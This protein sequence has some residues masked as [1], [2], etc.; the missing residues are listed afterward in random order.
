MVQFPKLIKGIM[1]QT[2][3]LTRAARSAS[4]ATGKAADPGGE[5]PILANVTKGKTNGEPPAMRSIAFKA[6]SHSKAGSGGLKATKG[7][8]PPRLALNIKPHGK[9]AQAHELESPRGEDAKS[10]TGP[11]SMESMPS[12]GVHATLSDR[13]E[14]RSDEKSARRAETPRVDRALGETRTAVS[15]NSQNQT[16][17]ETRQPKPLPKPAG[18]NAQPA[19]GNKPGPARAA[20]LAV[21]SP[22]PAPPSETKTVAPNSDKTAQPAPAEKKS[23]AQQAL[24]DD[25]DA[26]LDSLG[27]DTM[28]LENEMTISEIQDTRNNDDMKN[29]FREVESDIENILSKNKK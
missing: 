21:A 3:E 13:S 28:N 18:P 6:A 26:F 17:N 5:Q 29:L 7:Q 14:A 23:V 19:Q 9:K 4:K 24:E 10:D 15:K 1:P 8:K 11:K 2:T 12:G 25:L 20:T 27:K 16:R 22:A